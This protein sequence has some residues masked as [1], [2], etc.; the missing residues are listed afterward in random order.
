MQGP[1]IRIHRAGPGRPWGGG[2]GGVTTQSAASDTGPNEAAVMAPRRCRLTTNSR[3][4]ESATEPTTRSFA[5][6]AS[7]HAWTRGNSFINPQTEP[8]LDERVAL[9]EGRVG[10]V[11]EAELRAV[12]V[13]TVVVP[14]LGKRLLELGEP[15]ARGLHP[16]G[17]RRIVPRVVHGAEVGGE[18]RDEVGPGPVSR[19]LVRVFGMQPRR[20]HLVEVLRDSRSTRTGAA[21]PTESTGTLPC[22]EIARNQSGFSRRLI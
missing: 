21:Q 6:S 20:D 11:D 22:G 19:A 2:P 10:G 9:E 15:P 16:P 4:K 12:E 8:G 14:L 13:G 3:S 17:E 1:D 18:I 5:S 7:D